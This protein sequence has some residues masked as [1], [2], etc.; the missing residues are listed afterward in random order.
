M[1]TPKSIL[2]NSTTSNTT[3]TLQP[4]ILFP[5]PNRQSIL[6]TK[7]LKISRRKT[8]HR[9]N[10]YLKN[11]KNKY[12]TI[13]KSNQHHLNQKC[14]YHFNFITNP[15]LSKQQISTP[16]SHPN[17]HYYTDNQETYHITI[18]APQPNHQQAQKTF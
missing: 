1:H 11:E 3:T 12:Q 7:T 17:T 6:S 9:K 13:Q 2:S 15:N 16:Q 18:F 14:L 10:G 5:Q 4:A 8:Q